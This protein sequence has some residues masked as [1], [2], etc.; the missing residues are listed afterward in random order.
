MLK[1]I[2]W[3]ET[4]LVACG[5]AFMLM[6][7]GA[8]FSYLKPTYGIPVL[9]ALFFIGVLLIWRAYSEASKTSDILDKQIVRPNKTAITIGN[10]SPTIVGNNNTLIS[11]I[12]EE[13]LEQIRISDGTRIHHAYCA[14]NA[15]SDST[16]ISCY[17]DEYG[18]GELIDVHCR[19][20]AATVLSECIPELKDGDQIDVIEIEDEWWS[21]DQYNGYIECEE[22]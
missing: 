20:N 21:I 4:K 9:V 13:G 22:K 12:T 14:E 11:G 15:P 1:I 3:Y 19:V 17:L 18:T 10:N 16:I 6:A 8:V 2:K 7:I 5:E